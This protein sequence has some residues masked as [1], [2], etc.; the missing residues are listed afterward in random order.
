MTNNENLTI[1][2]SK[3]ETIENMIYEVRG[4]QVMLV[5]DVARIYNSETK[6]INQVVKRDLKRFP[7]EF[8]FQLN[9]VEYHSLRSQIVTSKGQ[10]NIGRGGNRDLPYVFTE[11]GVSMLATVFRITVA[12]EESFIKNEPKYLGEFNYVK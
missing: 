10:K 8:C 6:V 1:V 2:K 3:E 5:S 7:E 11:Y 9:E 12:E 4:V